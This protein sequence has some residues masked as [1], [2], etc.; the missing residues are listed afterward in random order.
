MRIG[1]REVH[2]FS[3]ILIFLIFTS[4]FLQ[5]ESYREVY[6]ISAYGLAGFIYI[7][8]ILA[9]PYIC[10]I[11]DILLQLY[12]CRMW[13]GIYSFIIIS[14]HVFLAFDFFY[15]FDLSLLLSSPQILYIS[16]GIIS[17]II[18]LLMTITSNR[19][20][21]LLLKSNWKRLHNLVYIAIFLIFI[22]SVN[23]ALLFL[24]NFLLQ[25]I[26]LAIILILSVYKIKRILRL[27]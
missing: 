24:N 19:Y 17:F 25:I 21:M 6:L 18:L 3:W 26:F 12:R 5:P 13:L 4:S 15:L 16:L 7:F 9:L 14:I 10:K 2:I 27:N 11:D 1:N 23:M 20:S 22:H 8:F